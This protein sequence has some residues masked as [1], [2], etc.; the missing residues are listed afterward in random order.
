M[1]KYILFL[2]VA[3]FALKAEAQNG[4]Q[5][6]DKGTVYQ[7][8]SHNTGDRIK[9]N[10]IVTFEVTQKTEKDSILFSTYKTGTPAQ[11]QVQPTGDLMD[12]FPLLAVNDSV[13]IKVPT[14]TIFKGQEDKR[15]PFFPKGSSLLFIMKIDK[16]QSLNDAIAERDR[17]I[18]EGKELMA[19][20]AADEVTGAIKYITDNKLI[21][22]TTPSGLKYKITKPSVKRK[23]LVGDTVIV[24]YTGRSLDGKVFDTS[25]AANGEKA[26]LERP[27]EAYQP[28]Q[29]VLGNSEV[30]PGWDEGLLLLNEGSKA[31]FM[32]PSKLAYGE[33]G[34][35]ETIKPFSTLLF[36]IEL[37]KIKRGKHAL[38]KPGTTGKTPAKK[39]GAKKPVATKKKN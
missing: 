34:S 11:A 39:T 12:I 32:I 7:L 20:Y 26:G 5:R 35:G 4:F 24:N 21:L 9:L 14:D 30:I 18:A 25:I 36:D 31:T 29:F 33:R 13:L 38:A 15:P 28:F 1:K 8:L 3:A 6:T 37:V 27:A 17:Q 19:K 16:V 22:R 2:F 23:P 10:D